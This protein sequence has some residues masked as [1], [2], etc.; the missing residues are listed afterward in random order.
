MAEQVRGQGGSAG[1]EVGAERRAAAIEARVV[2]L[3]E[4]QSRGRRQMLVIA[5]LVLVMFGIF[6]LLTTRQ[7]KENLREDRLREAVIARAPDVQPKLEQHLNDVARDVMPVYRDLAV[8]RFKAVGPEVAQTAMDRLKTL[9]A[10]ASKQ[11]ET[12]VQAS[13]ERVLARIEPEMAQRYPSLTDARKKELLAT[14]FHD[15]V[16]VE[17]E[18]LASKMNAIRT[19]ESIRMDAVLEKFGVGDE[20]PPTQPRERERQF[21]HALVDVL[22]D[23]DLGAPIAPP[24]AQGAGGATARL[25]SAGPADLGGAT[26]PA[27]SSTAP[28]TTEPTTASTTAPATAPAQ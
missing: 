28:A 21:L 5:V 11:I 10:D 26:D 14:Y 4:A 12:Q 22:M 2:K 18:Q 13:R 24:A 9:P 6:A 3:I 15:K 27:T 8:E 17:N 20:P 16:D 19:S 7:V 23:S 1:G 25:V